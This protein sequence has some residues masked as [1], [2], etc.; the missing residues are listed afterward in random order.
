MS[1]WARTL[2]PGAG[3]GRGWV[4]LPEVGDEVLVAFGLG[5]FDEPYV[6]GGLYNGK[7]A[8]TVPL[9]KHVDSGNGSIVRRAFVSRTGM[10]LELLEDA[11]KESVNLS[12]N[13]GKQRVTLVQKG[14]AA[15][16]I[17]S[18]GPVTVTAKKAVKVSTSGGDISLESTS[19][20]ISLKGTNV[21]IEAKS[22]CAVKGVNV[23][24]TAQAAGELS[25]TTVKVAGQGTAEL[26]ASGPTTVKGAVVKIN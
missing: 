17:I 9:D 6:L 13:D 21:T 12:T 2:Q 11:G 7:D 22:D 3:K 24:L 5:D 20:D 19:G 10:L 15:I 8:P 18:E 26:S 14:D 1:T 16:E 4:V 25:G 23:K